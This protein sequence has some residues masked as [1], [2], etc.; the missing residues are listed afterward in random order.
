M[1][2]KSPSIATCSP[3][4]LP[5]VC[6]WVWIACLTTM[7]FGHAARAATF[8]QRLEAIVAATDAHLA[9]LPGDSIRY[10][11]SLRRIAWVYLEGDDIPD[12]VLILK[13]SK[14]NCAVSSKG[15][16]PCKGLIL[17][18]SASGS[19]SVA[20][21]FTLGE[22]PLV[23][24]KTGKR[25]EAMYYTREISPE[26]HYSKFVLREGVFTKVEATVS[27]NE[28]SNMQAFITDDRSLPLID[29]ELYAAKQFD[30]AAARMAPFRLHVDSVNSSR[31]RGGDLIGD[32]LYTERSEYL[33]EALAPQMSKVV[34]LTA[35]HQTLELRLWSCTDWMVTR[36][37]WSVESHRLGKVGVCLE[38]AVFALKQGLVTSNAAFV[39]MTRYRL[40]QEIG[41]A[42][43]LRVAPITEARR[44]QLKTPAAKQHLIALGSAAGV[45]LGAALKLQ[46]PDTV[47][48]NHA[49]WVATS[50]RWFSVY[51][52]GVKN[53]VAK[54][55]ELRG[56]DQDLAV[57]E[58]AARCALQAL[59]ALRGERCPKNFANDIDMLR[60]SIG[61]AL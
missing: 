33:V 12:A 14:T 39:S 58:I 45:L 30:N 36:Q 50:D 41:T 27:R 15:S 57:S 13:Q 22:H 48:P 47:L 60:A 37:F 10:P 38:P 4:L 51:E 42:Y 18:G 40:L 3:S 6:R 31:F 28:I 61:E 49:M 19:Y 16:R 20:T 11:A 56:F 44:E 5:C 23:F 1:P 52:L 29:D 35:W 34:A 17:V 53:F 46:P 7:L 54:S 24:R 26:P 43:V 21:E 8:G 25:V 59:G 32:A 9:Q 55:P 2:H